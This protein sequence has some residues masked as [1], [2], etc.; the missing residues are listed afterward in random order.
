MADKR[1]V[2]SLVAEIAEFDIEFVTKWR[3]GVFSS[4]GLGCAGFHERGSEHGCAGFHDDRGLVSSKGSESTNDFCT[5]LL[6][7]ND[8][9]DAPSI[10][11]VLSAAGP[12][13]ND[14]REL[15]H[16]MIIPSAIY[17]SLLATNGTET[18]LEMIHGDGVVVDG[19]DPSSEDISDADGGTPF[20]TVSI[21]ELGID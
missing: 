19:E 7:M 9:D 1:L 16:P 8:V 13:L 3:V 17:P 21:N 14:P 10:S 15:M 6:S 4:C 20:S 5:V 2:S 11:F 12:H 18:R